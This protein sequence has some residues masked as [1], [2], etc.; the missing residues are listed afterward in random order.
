MASFSEEC[1]F[2]D[3]FKRKRVK[4]TLLDT[5]VIA[6]IQR[7]NLNKTVILEDVY[8]V[9]TGRKFPGVKLIFGHDIVKVEFHFPV[10]HDNLCSVDDAHK[11]TFQSLGNGTI[12]DDVVEHEDSMN[13]VLIDELQE[14]F[15]PAVTHIQEQKVIGIGANFFGPVEQERLCWLQVATKNVVYIFDILLLGAR[16]FKNGLCMILEKRHIL[17]VTHDCRW[18]VRCLRA[19]FNVNL[20]N[21]FDTQVADLMLFYKDTGGFLPNRVSTLQEVVRIHLKVPVN[22]LSPLG[23]QEQCTE[24]NPEVWYIRP[25]PPVLLKIMAVSVVHLLPLRLVLLDALMSDYTILVDSY[26]SSY[27]NKSVH[28]LHD[29]KQ[30]GVELPEEMQELEAVRQERMKWA[31]HCYLVTDDGLLDRS[32]FK[33]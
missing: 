6:V 10:N 5:Q 16:A 11:T 19:Q 32:S 28:M 21:V 9:Q 17:K 18:I 31:S 24:E 25:C 12:L 1:R 26:M 29:G 8:E 4:I 13:Y 22:K 14:K 30:N 27:Q 7:I 33:S 15:G 23:I 2:L 3:C 20:T